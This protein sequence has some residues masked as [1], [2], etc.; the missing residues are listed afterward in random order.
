MG[1]VYQAF[2][3]CHGFYMA[4]TRPMKKPLHAVNDGSDKLYRF[5]LVSSTEM[6]LITKFYREQKL[7]TR[8]PVH[9]CLSEMSYCTYLTVKSSFMPKCHI[10]VSTLLVISS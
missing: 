9:H 2:A 10:K 1:S 4:G 7:W 3:L 5:V 8:L 6:C